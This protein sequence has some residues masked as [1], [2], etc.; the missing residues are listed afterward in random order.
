[1]FVFQTK[2][3]Q[4]KLMTTKCQA[5]IRYREMRKLLDDSDDN[6][7]NERG[8]TFANEESTIY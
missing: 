3:G 6:K 4:L 8:K 1:M 2:E 5:Y 7:M